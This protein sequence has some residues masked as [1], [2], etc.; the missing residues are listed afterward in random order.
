MKRSI[1][2]RLKNLPVVDKYSPLRENCR[3][4]HAQPANGVGNYR[5]RDNSSELNEDITRFEKNLDQEK[6]AY[7]RP[8]YLKTHKFMKRSPK[9]IIESIT[10]PKGKIMVNKDIIKDDDSKCI[11]DQVSSH[12]KAKE[13]KP[14]TIKSSAI[15]LKKRNSQMCSNR[16]EDVD[17]I[18][19]KYEIKS[20]L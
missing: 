14:K 15:K 2:Q 7:V 4:E 5:Y 18:Q 13:N 1:G 12:L 6:T 17:I 19:E 11:D 10:S 8:L 9:K 20:M 16:A 3:L